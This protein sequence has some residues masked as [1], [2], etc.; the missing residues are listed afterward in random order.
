VGWGLSTAVFLVTK[1][2]TGRKYQLTNL[3]QDNQRDQGP[4][5]RPQDP[6]TQWR[7]GCLKI[8]E[9]CR[10][11]WVWPEV[12]IFYSEM[13]IIQLTKIPLLAPSLMKHLKPKHFSTKQFF[14]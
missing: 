12:D 10:N 8:K 5:P 3:A 11:K 14:P 9:L 4:K 7:P 6:S 1:I 2:K 13:F